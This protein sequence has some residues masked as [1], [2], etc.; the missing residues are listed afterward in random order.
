MPTPFHDVLDAGDRL[1]A[2]LTAGD[3]SRAAAELHARAALIDALGDA[4]GPPPAGLGERFREQDERLRT[5]LRGGLRS[6]ADDLAAT[7]RTAAAAGAYARPAP[8]AR[9]DTGRQVAVS[10]QTSA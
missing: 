2:A 1:V 7:G 6:L 4:P 10:S 3:L 5:V 8:P 9:L